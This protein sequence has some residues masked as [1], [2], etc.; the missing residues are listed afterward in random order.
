VPSKKP[1]RSATATPAAPA[2]RKWV[3]EVHKEVAKDIAH[4]GLSCPGLMPSWQDLVEQLE[5][6]PK[7]FPKKQGKLKRA[8]AAQLKHLNVVYRVAFVIEEA[9]RSVRIVACSLHDQAYKKP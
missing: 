7:R 6:N 9:R 8:R 2:A 4:Y 1:T 5:E 3:V